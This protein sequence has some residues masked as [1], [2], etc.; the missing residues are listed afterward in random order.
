M[1]SLSISVI[2]S[3]CTP[4]HCLEATL[5]A[6]EAQEFGESDIECIVVSDEPRD[7]AVEALGSIRRNV[8]LSLLRGC[9]T[10]SRSL[11][12]NKAWKAAQGALV[13]FLD[14]DMIPGPGWLLSYCRAF[15][16]NARAIVSG[17]RSC[18]P[19]PGRGPD[20]TSALAEQM[21]TCDSMLFRVNLPAQYD[22]LS[23]H[24]LSGPFS[25]ADLTSQLRAVCQRYPES[26]VRGYCLGSSNV[27][28]SREALESANGFAPLL[29]HGSSI[30]LGIRLA[31]LGHTFAMENQAGVYHLHDPEQPRCTWASLDR[32]AFLYL[33]PRRSSAMIAL[34][35]FGTEK[36]YENSFYP[37]GLTDIAASELDSR[38]S[39]WQAFLL[40]V[41]PGLIPGAFEYSAPEMASYFAEA[42]GVDERT[43]IAY[44][45]Q[46]VSSGLLVRQSGAKIYFDLQHTS[47][48]LRTRTRYQEHY[49]TNA[50]FARTHF[51]RKN[52]GVLTDRIEIHCQGQYAIRLNPT[53]DISWD[54]VVVNM[55]VP[56]EHACQRDVRLTRFTPPEL[57]DYL[58]NATG[59]IANVPGSLCIA[60]GNQIA[61]EFECD[62]AEQR[63]NKNM[64]ADAYPHK[65]AEERRGDELKVTLPASSLAKAK[66][67]L[68]HIL[69]GAESD[70]KADVEQIYRWTVKNLSYSNTPLPDYSVF[71]T[72]MGTCV[73]LSRLFLNLLRLRGVPAREQ[74]GALMTQHTSESDLVTVGRGHSPFSHTWVEVNVDDWGWCPVDLII[75]GYGEWQLTPFNVG[76]DLRC[77]MVARS[78]ALTDYYFGSI[79]PYRVYSSGWANKIPPIAIVAA[80]ERERNHRELLVHVHHR[81][82][83][84]MD[85]FRPQQKPPS[86]YARS[87]PDLGHR[88]AFVEEHSCALGRPHV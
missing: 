10:L 59:I 25:Y 48:W 26:I 23:S 17:P 29:R 41:Q 33:H 87:N 79:D 3:V 65:L 72:G 13:I 11:S 77:E 73:Q 32:Q 6:I 67:L 52:D 40:R 43:V 54:S 21:G 56:V 8:R 5:R 63:L 9:G 31:E 20:V 28:I 24:S 27:M 49:L 81:L 14:A 51:H 60:H 82:T 68:D 12:L 50:S 70:V 19:V 39:L 46:A 4:R 78:P 75:M 44:L 45:D 76:D 2:L 74:C 47:N 66:A 7:V 80:A 37:N 1:Q 22:Y 34:D 69:E 86:T 71:D 38:N 53:P 88:N 62:I 16:Q 84:R 55:S 18:L 57:K 83:C 58:D 36:S 15:S 85:E 61:Y 64:K 35:D 30:D 42:G